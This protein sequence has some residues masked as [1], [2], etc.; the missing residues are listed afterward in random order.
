LIKSTIV[1]L[2]EHIKNKSKKNIA[3]MLPLRL[4]RVQNVD[5]LASNTRLLQND[6][7]L[8]V[9]LDF[10]RGAIMATEDAT[11]LGI[12]VKLQVF[13]TEGSPNKLAQTISSNNIKQFDAVIE[14][15][16]PFEVERA[17][18]D[19][20]RDEVAVFSPL[21]NRTSWDY[22]NLFQTLPT[23]EE[24]VN[25]MYNYI[26]KESK[27]KNVVFVTDLNSQSSKYNK[28]QKMVPGITIV[29][30][31]EKGFL[32]LNE[33]Q[34]HLSR[35]QENWIILESKDPLLVSNVVGML[36][37]IVRSYKMQLLTTDKNS[38]YDYHD[39]SNIHLARLKFTFPSINKRSNLN[40]D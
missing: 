34:P 21:T 18:R 17:A 27:G 35:E 14:L 16:L 2:R 4:S 32:Y 37:G 13:D 11:N 26:D 28:I 33:I 23:E 3:L 31:T 24:L 6:V 39:V 10:Y 9:A 38:A 36:N 30:P 22:R 7:T 15:I 8:Q 5:S 19:L 40:E 25:L 1:D 29:T 20:Q 12:P